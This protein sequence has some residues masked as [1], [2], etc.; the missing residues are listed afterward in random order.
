MDPITTLMELTGRVGWSASGSSG[1]ADPGRIRFYL[2]ARI[3]SG[4]TPYPVSRSL[5]HTVA[6][7][8]AI[9]CSA[10]GVLHQDAP[11]SLDA[12]GVDV[13]AEEVRAFTREI[14]ANRGQMERA[15]VELHE[16]FSGDGSS[17]GS[18][19]SGSG[20]VFGE[21]FGDSYGPWAS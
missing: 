21:V 18:D 4:I 14:E 5:G 1:A 13:K 6:Q 17:G 9:H 15:L 3:H 10:I 16:L 8:S 20:E 19:G 2:I 7:L 12:N 11:P